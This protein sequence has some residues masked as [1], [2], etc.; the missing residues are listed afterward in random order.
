MQT[1]ALETGGKKEVPMSVRSLLDR[2][3]GMA[4]RGFVKQ[5]SVVAVA[6]IAV[7]AC[8]SGASSTPSGAAQGNNLFNPSNFNTSDVPWLSANQNATGSPALGRTLQIEGSTDLSAAADPQ[9]EYE[10]IG[11]TLERAYTRQLLSYPASTNQTK[12]EALVPD[13]ATSMPTLSADGLTY[14]FTLRPGLKWNTNPPRPVTSGDFKRGVL[15]NCDPTLAPNGN[16]GY[17]IATIAGFKS[18]CTAFEAANPSESPAARAATINNATV[19]GIQTPNDTTIVFTLTQPATDFDSIIALP[20]ASAA[21]VE[22]LTYTPLAPGNILYSDGPYYISKYS[23]GHQIVL[24]RNPQWSQSTDP[25]RH[26][27]VNEIDVKLDLAGSAAATEVQQDLSAGT[28]DLEWNTNVPPADIHGLESPSW[29]PQLGVFPAPG[30]TNPYLVFNV[31]SPNNAGALGK[32]KVRQALEYAIDKVAINKIYGGASLNEPL[33]QVIAPGAEGYVPFN[34]YSANNNQGNPAKCKS[35]LKA[36]GYPNGF[37]LKDYYR[38]S[39]NHPAV[40]QEVQSDFA[41][42][43]VT[44][45][46]TP[47]ATGYYG[48]SG[49]GVT[50]PD[51]LKAGRWDITEP[52]WIPDWFGPTNGRA[53]LPDL[54]DGALNFPGSDWGG[55]D[56]PLVDS[57]V[58]QAESATTIAAAASLWHQAD[59]QVMKDAPFIPFETSLT[60]L[61][62]AS[63]VHN[64]IFIPFSEYY[65]ITQV[66]L[67]S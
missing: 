11:Y 29:N 14:T 16:P 18:F 36:A 35:L 60:P 22:Y 9:G 49:I 17:Y 64:A 31:Q 1:P 63:R 2:R 19:S 38:N 24:S 8:G 48:S 54:F 65:D 6:A 61:F 33:N 58:T 3:T 46:G 67:S 4:T 47:I 32:V 43:G 53:T 45:V 42:C 23:V 15:R 59:E 21:P 55:Y 50:S 30:T 52:G 44:V 5:I 40:F 10:T 20:F 26:Q 66:W 25:I 34:D 37:T 57:L 41:R 56:N 13:A 12:A 27:Y 7:V 51:G 39:G 28:A 62:R